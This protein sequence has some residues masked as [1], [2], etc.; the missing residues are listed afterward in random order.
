MEMKKLLR[1]SE[2]D[3]SQPGC[4]FLT[5]CAKEKHLLFGTGFVGDGVLDDPTAEGGTRKSKCT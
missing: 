3:Y 4:Y 2:Y 5:L 1:L